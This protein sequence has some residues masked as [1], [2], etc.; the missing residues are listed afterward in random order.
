MAKSY[1]EKLE[2]AFCELAELESADA[3]EKYLLDLE[4]SDSELSIEL[5]QI[6]DQANNSRYGLD[7]S[8]ASFLSLED[9]QFGKENGNDSYDEL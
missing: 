3:R 5:R 6:L 2:L 8:E 7:I 1:L 9:T 4:E